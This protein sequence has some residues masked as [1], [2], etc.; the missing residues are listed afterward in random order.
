MLSLLHGLMVL[1]WHENTLYENS[2][3]LNSVCCL[4]MCRAF[5]I[6]AWKRLGRGFIYRRRRGEDSILILVHISQCKFINLLNGVK[7]SIKIPAILLGI[8]LFLPAASAAA[9]L[10]LTFWY[11]ITFSSS[12]FI[13]LMLQDRGQTYNEELISSSFYS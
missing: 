8:G 2:I 7:K 5:C 13:W 4:M 12:S 9:C 6:P 3:C 11:R 1:E 10:H